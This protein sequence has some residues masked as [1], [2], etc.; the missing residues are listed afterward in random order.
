MRKDMKDLIVDTSRHKYGEKIKSS[1]SGMD[2]EQME[3]LP[4]KAGIRRNHT[5]YG[6]SFGDRLTPLWEFLKKNVGRPWNEVY[7]EIC[8][9]ADSR[10]IRGY[11][12]REHVQDYVTGSGGQ[13]H[14]SRYYSRS[15]PF[16]VDDDGLL[17][18]QDYRRYRYRKPSPDPDNC[19]VGDRL[20][21]RINGCWFEVWYEKED[22]SRKVWS[23]YQQRQVVEY[24]SDEVK[25]R[26]RQLSKRELR[27]LD[28]S[29][30][31]D[32]KWWEA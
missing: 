13:E 7:S 6:F 27:D 26:Q 16:Y 15:G 23:W 20:F 32:F 30:S 12:L 31:P 8:Q 29:N 21:E 9:C 11:H 25:V 10:S 28:L 3:S 5:D 17:C 19:K 2:L 22:K 14:L 18:F 4:T 1:V 24:Y